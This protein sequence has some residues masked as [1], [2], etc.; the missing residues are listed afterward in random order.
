MAEDDV[1]KRR[2]K[3]LRLTYDGSGAGSMEAFESA[4]KGAFPTETKFVGWQV[5]APSGESNVS[6]DIVLSLTTRWR[7][8]DVKRHMSA[9][10]DGG[11]IREVFLPVH[12]EKTREFLARQ[13][14]PSESPFFGDA[15][16][17]VA[18]E[19]ATVIEGVEND[20]SAERLVVSGEE[21]E[22][23]DTVQYSDAFVFVFV[24]VFVAIAVAAMSPPRIGLC[25]L[26]NGDD[27]GR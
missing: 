26:L 5:G 16:L 8:S 19:E 24:F 9:L 21:S 15:S 3:V 2:L 23:D 13:V 20:N 17:L 6:Y 7:V 1:N 12:Y 14:K 27:D 10:G 25:K 22:S 11:K 18:T 4:L